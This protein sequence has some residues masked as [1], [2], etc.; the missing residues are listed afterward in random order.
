MAREKGMEKRS[1]A[2]RKELHTPVSAC[3]LSQWRTYSELLI[4]E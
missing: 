3:G 4:S 1:E 2:V